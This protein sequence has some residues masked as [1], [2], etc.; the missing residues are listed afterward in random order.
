MNR[1]EKT[2][3]NKYKNNEYKNKEEGYKK[4]IHDIRNLKPYNKDIIININNL[5][6]EDRLEILLAYNEIIKY[7]LTIF[8]EDIWVIAP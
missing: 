1:E 3:D 5:S 8:E 7:C 4:Y 2:N 6:Y